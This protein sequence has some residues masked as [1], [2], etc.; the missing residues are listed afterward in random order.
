MIQEKFVS[1]I[2]PTYNRSE[3]IQ[4]AIKSILDQT[5]QHFEII[6]VDD[7]STDNTEDVINGYDNPKIRYVKL[8][9]NK[10]QCFAR[11]RGIEQSKGDFIA[12]LDSDDEWLPNK[13][14]EQIEV[15]EKGSEKLGAVY[16]NVYEYNMV[17]KT[18]ELYTYKFYRGDIYEH[19]IN[20]FCPPTPSLFL[21]KKEAIL[22]VGMFDESLLTFVDF[23]LWLRIS[24]EYEYDFVEA[25]LIIK[26]EQIGDEQY[27][28]NVPKRY[29]GLG[30][31]ISKWE[32]E[33]KEKGKYKALM[34]LKRTMLKH[35][36]GIN[37][38]Y[39]PQN[40]RENFF[41]ILKILFEMRSFSVK[42][43]L[44]AFIIYIIGPSGFYKLFRKN[45]GA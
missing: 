43:Y 31:L 1:I 30:L 34:K 17:T 4:K 8:K 44:K 22:K 6:V 18:K 20:G 33:F 42:Q 38:T 39:P 40:Y 14:K 23:D 2:I 29:K 15:F 32:S 26:Y 5:Y 10:G 21:V 41:L 24:K 19:I 13:L 45:Q 16:G 3:L 11:N 25:P 37:L 35:I 9:E 28:T 7:A 27:V 12:F 36:I